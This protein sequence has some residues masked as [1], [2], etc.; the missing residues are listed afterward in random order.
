MRLY[1]IFTINSFFK[2]RWRVKNKQDAKPTK[3]IITTMKTNVT[4]IIADNQSITQ[5]GMLGYISDI[6]DECVVDIVANKD[7]LIRALTKYGESLVIL[8]YT[9]FDIKSVEEFLVIE[10]RFY[11]AYWLLFSNEL[12]TDFIRRLSVEKNIGM[13]LKEN[14]GEEIRSALLCMANKDRFFCHQIS[15]LLISNSEK[16][17]SLSL[18][19][20]TETDIL[21]SIARGKSVKEI[22]SERNSSI[23]TIITHKK[24]FFG[25]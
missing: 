14:S 22:A 9:L 17:E 25:S 6:F 11:N 16:P 23:H 13:V 21:K 15:N 1:Y 8:D 4:L 19:T 10:K 12:S 5:R 24:I 2:E 18:L 7:E 3:L 20:A